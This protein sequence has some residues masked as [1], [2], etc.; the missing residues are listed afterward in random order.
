MSARQRRPEAVE[1]RK[2]KNYS[3]TFREKRMREDPEGFRAKNRAQKSEAY[4]TNPVQRVRCMLRTGAAKNLEITLEESGGVALVQE[5]CHYC[6]RAPDTKCLNGID[7]MD[8]ARGYVADNCVSCCTACN[9]MKKCLDAATFV[10]RCRHLAGVTY[11][12]DAWPESKGSSLGQYRR[13][14]GAVNREFALSKEGFAELCTAACAYCR[15]TNPSNGID[16]VDNSLGYV[17]GN[18]VSC[19][20]ECNFMKGGLQHEEF[21]VK[22]AA[23]SAAW[24]GRALPELSVSNRCCP[25]RRPRTAT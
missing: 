12:P 15:R 7:R 9:A 3:K 18:C 25:R 19:C 16:R 23:V 17:P 14:A 20:T 11:D 10:R 22:C 6:G 8:N 2:A 24:Q 13:N 5:A 4:R 1:K 21:T